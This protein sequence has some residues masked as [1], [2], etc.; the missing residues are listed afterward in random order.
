MSS[1]T[2]H[3]QASSDE[4]Q[5]V[6]R[7]LDDLRSG[8]QEPFVESLSD[9]DRHGVTLM[10]EA[11]PSV[12]E[13]RRVAAVRAMTSDAEQNIVRNYSRALLVAMDDENS[14]ARLNALEGLWELSSF[15]LLELLLDRARTEQ[16]ASVRALIAQ[17][18][19]RFAM[20]AE[21]GELEP[22]EGTRVRQTLMDLLAN[23]SSQLVRRRALESLGYFSDDAE[24]ADEIE[25]AYESGNFDMR[26]SAIR[27][28]G[29]QADSRWVSLCQEELSSDEPEVRYEAVTA[30]G[31]IGD[32]RSVSFVIDV[33]RDEDTEVRLAAI[34]ALGALGGQMAVNALRSVAKE[35]DPVLAEAAEEA[36]E[37]A[38]IQ[39][40]PLRPPF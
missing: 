20:Q 33:L 7:A 1:H 5:A 36:L 26:L 23:D 29:L 2:N 3:Q 12:P 40:N 15:D 35:D 11:W 9:L 34:G 37:E 30:V 32:P 6:Q 24:V 17:S 13:Q 31:Q 19:G 14:E 28:M 39:S 38:L 16:D 22:L 27:A 4:L 25:H 10:R 21:L 8:T 18:L